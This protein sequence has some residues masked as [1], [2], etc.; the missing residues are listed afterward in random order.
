M[1]FLL[2]IFDSIIDGIGDF[3]YASARGLMFDID[4]LKN[5]YHQ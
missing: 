3:I 4:K 1:N 2:A 5:S